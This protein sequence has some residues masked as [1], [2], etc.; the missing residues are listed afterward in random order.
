MQCTISMIRNGLEHNSGVRPLLMSRAEQQVC[1]IAPE[2]L[3]QSERV[4]F[5][6]AN[7]EQAAFKMHCD[8]NKMHKGHKTC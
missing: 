4:V 8:T 6:A 1:V 5:K 3:R 2:R 7:S